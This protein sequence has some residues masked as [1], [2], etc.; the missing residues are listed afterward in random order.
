MRLGPATGRIL[1]CT[2]RGRYVEFGGHDCFAPQTID[3][4]SSGA[5]SL[6]A[7]SYRPAEVEGQICDARLSSF[8]RPSLAR[9]KSGVCWLARLS[10]KRTWR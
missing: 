8:V 9:S 6:F 5:L 4:D 7:M 3:A 2:P 10:A 1:R